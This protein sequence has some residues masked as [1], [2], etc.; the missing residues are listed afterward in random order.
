M[1]Q[2][3]NNENNSI[4][5]EITT[6]NI[7]KKVEEKESLVDDVFMEDIYR[8][9]YVDLYKLEG[10][11]IKDQSKIFSLLLTNIY[12]DYDDIDYGIIRKHA[13]RCLKLSCD[14]EENELKLPYKLIVTKEN[15]RM[16][17][18]FEKDK[19]L[20]IFIIIL[21]LF[22]AFAIA[23]TYFGLRYLSIEHLN[24]DINGDGIADLNIDM[25]GN[26]KAEI[27]ISEDRKKPS[28]NIDYKGN[29][30]AVFNIDADNTGTAT[31]NLMNQDIDGDGVCD[32]NCDTNDDGWPE[33]NIDLDGDG[34]ADLFID[35]DKD[36]KPDLNFDTNGDGTC[37]LHCDEDGDNL[38]D[39][40]CVSNVEVIED[41]TGNSSL[42]GN[43]NAN[44]ETAQ[45]IVD[46]VDSKQIII[47]E[48]F[49]EDQDSDLVTKYVTKKISIE[50]KS[51]LYVRYKIEL[52]VDS[53]TFISN[54]FV[55]N[56]KATNG[57]YE[58]DFTTVPK[59]TSIIADKVV[60]APRTKQTYE[61]TFKLKGLNVSQNFD[62]GRTF[63][64]YF[65]VYVYN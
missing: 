20:L 41:I 26:E 42:I 58:T 15:N 64:G 19:T 37:D 45:F 21:C 56:M 14:P 23:A 28:M 48:L 38:C 57:G 46:F 63:A 18:K 50:N 12:K 59:I 16:Y 47:K 17:F 36:G 29:R 31:K 35:T 40:S 30:K 6:E 22:I 60:I 27:N 8:D 33:I 62:Q 32:L 43:N 13:L 53:N 52:V 5:E 7:E 2:D 54:N 3:E 10:L 24:I 65:Q 44:I 49:P 4:K 9:N 55:Y 11:E 39:T 1:N 34:K 61:I 51:A 25:S